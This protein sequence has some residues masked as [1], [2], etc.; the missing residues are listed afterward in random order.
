MGMLSRAAVR[1][2]A[3]CEVR[4][5]QQRLRQRHAQYNCAACRSLKNSLTDNDLKGMMK[6]VVDAKTDKVL[7]IHL[8]GPEVA[9]ILQ[10]GPCCVPGAVLGAGCT[11]FVSN[12]C[13]TWPARCGPIL[14]AVFG[15]YMHFWALMQAVHCHE[16]AAPAAMLRGACQ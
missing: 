9:E 6:V 14:Q 5:A 13:S 3:C 4:S 1:S 16:G 15:G 8:V 11:H 12:R 7:G 2:P 10:V